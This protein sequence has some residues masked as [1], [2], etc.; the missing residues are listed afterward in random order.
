[1]KSIEVTGKN[2]DDA[3]AKALQKLNVA[4]DE[5]EYEVIDEGSKG[6]FNF[7]G[8]KPAKLIVSLKKNYI[9]NAKEFLVNVLNSMG[10]E[11]QIKITEEGNTIKIDLEGIKRGNVIGYRGETLDSLQYLLSLVKNYRAKR[12]ETLKRVAEK[13]AYKVKKINRAYKLEPMNP[14]ERRIIHS[15]LQDKEG[16]FTYSEGEEPYR[17]VVVDIKPKK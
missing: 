11:P 4:K 3:I 8:S 17:R 16:I 12:E 7:I 6:L 15:A 5:I 14:Y 13:T 9:D 1:M 2:V 10:I